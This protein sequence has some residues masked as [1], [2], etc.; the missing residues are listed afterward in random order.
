SPGMSGAV[1][2]ANDSLGQSERYEINI[3]VNPDLTVI[4]VAM[5]NPSEIGSPVNFSSTTSG[6]TGPD[7]YSWQFGDG[8]NSDLQ[9]PSYL[10]SSP[11]NYTARLWVNDS[12]GDAVLG[13]VVIPIKPSLTVTLTGVSSFT[14]V[15]KSISIVTN[16]LGGAAPYTY[17]Y[18]GLPPGCGPTT[19]ASLTCAPSNPGSYLVSATVHDSLG[20]TA[21]ATLRLA[22]T[23]ASSTDSAAETP[24]IPATLGCVALIAGLSIFLLI[25]RRARAKKFRG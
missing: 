6:G 16:V 7:S 1:V 24:I 20:F 18:L 4:V 17:G 9:N 3:T 14:E 12:I 23:P 2:W 22:V 8:G 25:R 15:G 13:S 5:P 21:R 19:A 11:G 10:Y